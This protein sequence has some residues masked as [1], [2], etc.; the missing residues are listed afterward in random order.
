MLSLMQG[1]YFSSLILTFF[2]FITYSLCCFTG[3]QYNDDQKRWCQADIGRC[4]NYLCNSR[5][6]QEC[7]SNDIEDI[8]EKL[9]CKFNGQCSRLKDDERFPCMN[10]I[11]CPI[12]R[13]CRDGS[14]KLIKTGKHCVYDGQ[15]DHYYSCER[16]ECVLSSIIACD[17]GRSCPAGTKCKN[18]ICRPSRDK[19]ACTYDNHCHPLY[20]CDKGQCILADTTIDGKCAYNINCPTSYKCRKGRCKP[21]NMGR[22]CWSTRDCGDADYECNKNRECAL[23]R[24]LKKCT[25]NSDC[26]KSKACVNGKCT[27]YRAALDQSSFQCSWD[28]QCFFGQKCIN[29]TCTY[30]PLMTRLPECRK[31]ANCFAADSIC[32]NGKCVPM[33]MPSYLIASRVKPQCRNSMD[34]EVGHV[35]RND[36]CISTTR[37]SQNA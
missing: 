9:S 35:C 16:N 6:N 12:D 34:C 7:D 22:F 30:S 36:K 8:S 19:S 25:S 26:S 33:R 5:T 27:K 1:L 29:R 3:G 4:A 21:F 17:N 37:V 15:C 2:G 23:V 14:C 10:N 13:K 32:Q 28:Q 31:N 24:H 20:R 18:D 11:D